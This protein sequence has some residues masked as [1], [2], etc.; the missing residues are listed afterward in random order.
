MSHKV[1]EYD[2]VIIGSGA[3]G[4]TVAKELSPLC[5]KGYRIALLEWGGHFQPKDNTREE[6]TMAERYYFDSGGF[7]TQQ[8][9]MTLAFAK[10][11]GGTTTVYTGTSL[12]APAETFK[13][14]NVE[15]IE[16]DDF[17]PRY[18]KYISENN[19]HLLPDDELNDNNKR[20]VEG[21]K[22]LSWNV[23]QFPVNT[24]GCQGLAT[25]NLGCA[26]GAKQ[27]TAIVQIPVAQ[28][29]GVDVI[30]FCRVDRIQDHE[31][32]AEV[33]EP[34]FGLEPSQLSVGK[35]L[36]R[37][38][39]IVVCG[40]AI[41]SPALLLRSFPKNTWPS[42]GCYFTCHPALILVSKHQTPLHSTYGHPKSFYCDHFEKSDHFILETCMYFPFTL[43]KNLTGFGQELD[44]LVQSY[45]KLQMILVLAIDPAEK[46]NRIVIDK[47]GKPQ[48]HYKFHERSINSLIQASRASAKIFFAGGAEQVHAPGMEQF[49][50]TKDQA[51][52]VDQIIQRKHF[53]LGKVSIAAAHL[54]GGCRMGEDPNTSVT[55]SWGRLHGF[56]DC[57][58][59]DASLFPD[60]LGINPY[61]TIMALADRVAEGIKKDLGEL[62]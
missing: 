40:G 45:D 30:T 17:N 29:N 31:I 21:C 10:A 57:Y 6:V 42:L 5:K 1:L 16:L 35:Y 2:I 26:S 37:C 54:M 52:H 32:E 44:D 19:V 36:F 13:R 53:Q 27:G 23:E 50:M 22:K 18:E 58:V 25:C 60:A 20:F 51:D 8:Q 4:G 34:E 59:A 39:K 28:E 55:N 62:S 43:A 14:W 3:G 33:L 7:Q 49:L 61:L 11:L 56:E 15:G 47:Q 24:K 38:K 12:T 9:D 41:N 46:H 48:L